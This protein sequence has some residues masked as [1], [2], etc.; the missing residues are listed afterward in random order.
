VAYHR[1]KE[2]KV[3]ITADTFGVKICTLLGLYRA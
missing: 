1:H 3:I 2:T